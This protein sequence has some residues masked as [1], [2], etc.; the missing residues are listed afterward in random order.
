M[1]RVS[2]SVKVALAGIAALAAVLPA[3][4]SAGVRV[5]GIDTSQYPTGRG[6]VVSSAGPGVQPALTENGQPVAV[7]VTIP[8]QFWIWT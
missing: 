8:V 1:S 3:A 5:S 2:P 6:T 7:W 4:A